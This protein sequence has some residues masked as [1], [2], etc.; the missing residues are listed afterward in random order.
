MLREK[1]FWTGLVVGVL[2]V[3]VFHRVKGIPSN[4][5]GSNRS[6]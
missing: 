4:A 5:P 6:A 3:Y 1:G 2:G